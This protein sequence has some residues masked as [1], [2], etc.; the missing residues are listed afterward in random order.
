MSASSVPASQATELRQYALDCLLLSDP[1]SKVATVHAMKAAWHAGALQ[2][3][4]QAELVSQG[5]IRAGRSGR[6]WCRR[7]PWGGARWQPA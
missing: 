5:T 3:D 7:S 1:A 6:N 2:L 4:E